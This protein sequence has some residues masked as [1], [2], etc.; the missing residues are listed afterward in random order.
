MEEFKERIE[1]IMR[2]EN[3]TAS[4]FAEAIGIQRSAISHIISGRNKVS[5]DVLRKTLNRYPKISSD[6]MMFGILP[7]YREEKASS[8]KPDL[9][10]SSSEGLVSFNSSGQSSEGMNTQ[11][12]NLEMSS[13]ESSQNTNNQAV[14]KIKEPSKKIEEI[15]IFYDDNTFDTFVPQKKVKG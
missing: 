2:S 3:L 7:M 9:F 4:R 1:E 6:W 8:T 5:L 14:I 10:K 15:L 12:E 13:L 11:S